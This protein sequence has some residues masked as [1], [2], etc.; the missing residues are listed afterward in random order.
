MAASGMDARL[1]PRG[2]N[3]E[4]A[5]MLV[6]ILWRAPGRARREIGRRLRALGDG[7]PLVMSTGRRG[8]VAVRTSLDPRAVVRA[9]REVAA[10]SPS[11]FRATC[12]WVPVDLW[13]AGDLEA[14]RRG[15]G[16]L[17]DR[18]APAERWRMTLEKRAPGSSP[19]PGLIAALA[20]L[21][22]ARVDL[23]HPDKI[24]LVQLFADRTAFSLL[25]PAEVFSLVPAPWQSRSMEERSPAAADGDEARGSTRM[26]VEE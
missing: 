21:I 2:E 13:T 19:T 14:M 7:S 5:N 12:K 20:E 1:E 3:L 15:V 9:L 10:T 11:R 17:R 22:P 23:A 4:E 8:I 6:S 18:I 25:A 26:D 16:E 24:L